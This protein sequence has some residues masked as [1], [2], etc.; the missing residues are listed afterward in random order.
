VYLK[1]IDVRTVHWSG[2][3]HFFAICAQIMRRI[4]VDAARKRTSCKHGGG[5]FRIDLDEP[6]D[7]TD[8]KDAQLINC[9]Q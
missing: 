6:F 5:F 9:P 1:L 8:E 2:R 7:L 3:A 4:L